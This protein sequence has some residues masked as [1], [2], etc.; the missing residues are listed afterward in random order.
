MNLLNNHQLRGYK[1]PPDMIIPDGWQFQPPD[2][3]NPGFYICY[4]W[5]TQFDLEHNT[6]GY[7][8]VIYVN[9]YEIEP[10]YWGKYGTTK[11]DTTINTLVCIYR[12]LDLEGEGGCPEDWLAALLKDAPNQ[13]KN[14][15]RASALETSFPENTV[16]AKQPPDPCKGCLWDKNGNCTADLRVITCPG[17][18][19]EKRA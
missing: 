14:R 3:T 11:L 12:K 1:I 9:G 8:G 4:G 15:P 16:S 18:K 2:H 17:D 19:K 7:L 10:V 13:F 6:P 5:M